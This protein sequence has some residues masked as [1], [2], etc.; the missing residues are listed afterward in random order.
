MAKQKKKKAQ[1]SSATKKDV[2]KNTSWKVIIFLSILVLAL[3]G[4][5]IPNKFSLD[6]EMVTN[7]NP[8]VKKGIKGIPEILR[9]RYASNPKQNYEYRPVV[10]IT[11]AIEQSLFKGNAHVSH[12]INV[13]LYLCLCIFIYFLLR[14]LLKSYH[15][16]LPLLATILFAAH[17]IHTE[18]VASLKNRD[19]ILSMFGSLVS[20]YSFIKFTEKRK[21][22]W[23]LSGFV[24]FI[25]AYFSKSSA[26]VF[27]ALIPVT[28]YFFTD[29]KLKNLLIIIGILFVTVLAARYFPRT[30]LPKTER[31][32]VYFENPLYFEKSIWLRFGTALYVL[33]FYLR[34]LI[35][36]H[37]LVFYYGYNVIP[38]TGLANAWVLISLLVYLVLFM[39]AI[40]LIRKKHLLSYCI[41][42]FMITISIYANLIKPPP[43]IVAERFLFV[44]SLGFCL[45]IVILLFMVFKRDYRQRNLNFK[46]IRMPVIIIAIILIPMGIKTI[47][48]NPDW[49]DCESLYSHDLQYLE[50]SAKA[51]SVYAALLSD[52][53]FTTKDPAKSMEYA[54]QSMH[55]YEQAIKVYPKYPTC[56]NNLGIIHYRVYKNNPDAIR[57]WREAGKYDNTYADPWYNIAVAYEN[58]NKLD[59]AEFY[60][61]TAVSVKKDFIIA[62]SNL[63][64]LYYKKGNLKKAISTNEKIMEVD[65]SSDI[66]YVNIGNYYLLMADT[67]QAISFWEKAIVKQPYNAKLNKTLSNYFKHIGNIEKANYYGNLANQ[68]KK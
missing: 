26:L 59:S 35:F 5:T 43:G 9:T 18:V 14:K 34:L 44:P 50:N 54:R 42:Y 7:S 37:P 46:A 8:V 67:I 4:N 68:I 40:W 21:W 20:L 49:K 32:I 6:D 3:Y 22:Y 16:W 12:L 56:W 57:C 45:A 61:Q 10:K 31:E 1:V 51:N 65:S 58:E 47:S 25:I 41:L 39:L 13:L 66:P 30:F 17:P 63:S 24:F 53:I 52:K 2:K 55:Y 60:Y 38:I 11:Y 33:L 19:E 23:V 15:P 62:Y 36:P 27:L 64:N 29:V 28:L 48:R